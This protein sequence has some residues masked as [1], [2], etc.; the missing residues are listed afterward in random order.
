MRFGLTTALPRDGVCAREF[1]QRVE[2]TGIDVLTFADHLAPTVSPFSGAAAAAAVTSRLRV[3]TLVLNNDFRHPVETARESA[4]V[5][6]VSGG[7]F[8]LGI[9]AGHMKSEYDAAGL[10]FDGGAVRVSRLA[11]SVAVIKAL[12]AG[13]AVDFDGDHYHVHAAAGEIVAVPS[14]PVPILVGGNGT[15]VLRLAGRVADIV[16]FAGISHNRD[17]TR[18]RLSHFDGAG[19]ANRI[20]VVRDAAGQRFA[21]I[22]LNAL[23]QAVVVTT[24]R[25]RAAAELAE[26]LD[27][28]P[29]TLLDSPFLLLGTHEQMAEQLVQ[30]QRE[31]GIGYWTVFDE[32]PGRE[33]ALPDIAEVIALL[34]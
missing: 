27:T 19:L 16:G 15:R 26:T 25:R 31:F 13:E 2:A 12:L 6:I 23:I 9:G 1:A 3:G 33:S 11:E 5:A 4:G 30:R 18:V 34:R 28:D 24:D 10:R 22:E 7:R 21:H 32:L 8:E 20:S 29:D 17:A 14:R